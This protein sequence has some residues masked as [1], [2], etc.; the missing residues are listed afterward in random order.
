MSSEPKRLREKLPTPFEAFLLA[1][2]AYLLGAA[3]W[4]H[5]WLRLIIAPIVLLVIL[6]PYIPHKNRERE[7][8]LPE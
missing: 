4:W 2:L 7:K 1:G 5:W 8:I 6:G 3:M